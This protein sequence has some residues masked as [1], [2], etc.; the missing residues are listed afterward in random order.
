M[1]ACACEGGAAEPFQNRKDKKATL[2]SQGWDSTHVL[3]GRGVTIRSDG[4]G[5]LSNRWPFGGGGDADACRQKGHGKQS[6]GR[7]AAFTRTDG[8]E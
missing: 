2:G 4:E 6:K 7:R 5:R 3:K 1:H 8:T